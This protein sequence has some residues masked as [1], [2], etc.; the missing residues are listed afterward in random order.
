MC[1]LFM[2]E[3]RLVLKS[4]EVSKRLQLTVKF[5]KL[6]LDYKNGRRV[7]Y[8]FSNFLEK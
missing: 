3:K 2:F 7:F 8:K 4:T 5:T 6:Q 1:I